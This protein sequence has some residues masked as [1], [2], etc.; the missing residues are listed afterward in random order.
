MGNNHAS[1]LRAAGLKPE[2]IVCGFVY[3]ADMEDYNPMNKIYR[4]YY[5][6]G[7]G[8]RTCL[9]PTAQTTKNVRVMGS[10]IAGRTQSS[11]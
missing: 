1:V 10:F 7:P 8:V 11:E 5:S 3:L 6:A 9:M 2:D 4:E